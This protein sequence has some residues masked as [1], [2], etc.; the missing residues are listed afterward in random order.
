MT[1][2]KP[3]AT[4]LMPVHNGEKHLKESIESILKQTYKDFEFLIINDGSTD[5]SLEIIN[6]Y[7][8][9]RIRLIHNDKNIGLA[10][11]LNKGIDL[12]LEK[13]IVR[14]DC[15]DISTKNRL[16][17]QVGYMEK[18]PEIGICGAWTWSIGDLPGRISTAPYKDEHIKAFLILR[19]AFAHPTV[20]LRKPLL[21]RYNLRYRPEYIVEDYGLWL[22]S[23][24]YFKMHNI[25]LILLN[26]RVVSTSL[27][28]SIEKKT[29]FDEGFKLIVRRALFE[30][31]GIS[32]N[33]RQM[34]IH[35]GDRSSIQK[36]AITLNE[37][38][39]WLKYIYYSNNSTRKFS[40]D[41][42]KAVLSYRWYEVC[43]YYSSLGLGTFKRFLSSEFRCLKYR[44]WQAARL[45][46]NCIFHR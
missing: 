37:A 10:C 12:A 25:P 15:D 11:T 38:Q 9:F 34:E 30:T 32:P 26:Y 41:A 43:S 44:P 5:S 2:R 24:N 18:H 14:M 28:H 33:D 3:I 36:N 46:K 17:F 19:S 7:N 35:E 39:E 21:D 1:Q 29:I 4:V 45:L 6:S 31:L 27:S 16:K 40:D 20:I 23:M 42:I 13:Y 22:D 8:D